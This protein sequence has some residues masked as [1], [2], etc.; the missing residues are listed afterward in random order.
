MQGAPLPVIPY[1][2]NTATV[3]LLKLF[4]LGIFFLLFL[5]SP[6]L[7]FV[8]VV[9]LFC[10]VLFFFVYFCCLVLEFNMLPFGLYLWVWYNLKHFFFP[11]F[12]RYFAHLH[13]QCYTKSPP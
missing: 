3:S 7:C 2:A 12:I 10:F 8:V 6:C 1:K 11:F 9:V 13:L 4:F 5:Y